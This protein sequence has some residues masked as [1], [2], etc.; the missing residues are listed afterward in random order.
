MV[1]LR[2]EAIPAGALGPGEG[3]RLAL[4]HVG[5]SLVFS[6]GLPPGVT[7]VWDLGS[8]AGLP[9]VP[10]GILM[11]GTGIVLV[12][13][14]GRRARLLRRVTRLLGLENVVVKET[15][16]ARLDVKVPALVSRATLPPERGLVVA[17]RLLL[18][19]GTAV[20]GGSWT[21]PPQAPGWE[22]VEIPE[23]ILDHRVW[24]LIMRPQ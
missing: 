20:W 2:E 16:L 15:D 9:G 22:T 23:E 7:E 5:D 1:W 21:E 13:R 14:S 3:S 10:L 19:G 17:E 8:G 18:P 12:E 11:P 4:R 24:L 6:A